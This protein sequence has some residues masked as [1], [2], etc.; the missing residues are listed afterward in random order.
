MTA[1]E[2][3][4]DQAACA[5]FTTEL[6]YP[7]P[8]DHAAVKAAKQICRDCPVIAECAAWARDTKEPFGIWGGMTPRERNKKFRHCGDW[9]SALGSARR[10]R[11]LASLGYGTGHVERELLEMGVT[12]MTHHGLGWIREK[13]IQT[14]ASKAAA[15]T[16]VYDRL[17]AR[18]PNDAKRSIISRKQAYQERWPTP[19]DWA[20]I[21]IYDPD[22]LPRPRA[23]AA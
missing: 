5:G 23:S 9:V 8:G 22:A 2:D 21:D 12:S 4:I 10:L 7:V 3:W 6:F 11:A 16:K 15:I 14:E 13:A 20:D 18:G 17:V 1:R 19:E